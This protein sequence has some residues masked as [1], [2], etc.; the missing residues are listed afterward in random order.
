[1]KLS[2]SLIVDVCFSAFIMFVLTFVLTGYFIERRFAI[3]FSVILSIPVAMIAYK[4]ITEKKKTVATKKIERE[5]IDAMNAEL[6][7]YTQTEINDLFFKAFNKGGF[8]PTRKN[9]AIYINA[10]KDVVLIRYGESGAKKTDVVKAFNL[11]SANS[12][13]YLLSPSFSDEL[14]SFIDRFSG[15]VVAV[16]DKKVFEF[17]DNLN[18][19][20]KSKFPAPVTP[21]TKERLKAAFFDRKKAKNFFL[22]GFLFLIMSIFV[23]LKL[24]Y[25]ILG[26][27]FLIYALIL[28]LFGTVS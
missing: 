6:S 16:N 4:K 18:C 26:S 10:K 14:L 8:N 15:S 5:K 12:K 28:K 19:I 20:P 3:A 22:F 27:L 24:Y 1:M 7:L 9:G 11:T 2:L 21:Q 13:A 25:I 17:L 23:N